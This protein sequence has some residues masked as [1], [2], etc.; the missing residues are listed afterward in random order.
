MDKIFRHKTDRNSDLM[1]AIRDQFIVSVTDPDGVIIEVNDTFCSISQYSREELIGKDHRII[2]SGFHDSRFFKH[3]WRTLKSGKSWRGEVCNRAKNGSIYWVDSVIT[4]V[5]DE[6]GNIEKFVSIRS[7]ITRKKLLDAESSDLLNI[8]RQQYIVS[9]TDINGTIIEV[10]DAFCEISQFSRS[11]LIG[12]NHRIVNSLHHSNAFFKDMW[13]TIRSGKSWH[14]EICNRAKDKSIYWV[15]SVIAPLHDSNGN[16]D[17]FVSIRRDVT[18]KKQQE[19]ENQDLLNTI[20]DQYIMS[21][22]DAKGLITDVNSAFCE[23]SG[24]SEKDLI[25]KDHRIVNSCEHDND[26]FKKMWRTVKSEKS[27]HGEI[28]NKAKDGS[29]YWVDSVITPLHDAEGRVDRFVSIRR[30]V[31]KK[32]KQAQ[33]LL[34]NKEMLDRT[35]KLAKIGGWEF[36]L[37]DNTIIWSKETCFIHGVESGYQPTLD[38]AIGFYAPEVQEK[39]RHVIERSI[40]HGESWDIEVPLIRTNGE[41]IHVRVVGSVEYDDDVASKLIGAIQD[42]SEQVEHREA[43]KRANERMKLAAD[44]GKIGIFEYDIINDVLIW[45]EWMY[46]LYGL[47]PEDGTV[48]YKSWSSHLHP[49]DRQRTER[50]FKQALDGTK[51]F[52]TEFRITWKDGSVRHIRGTATVE[53]DD[54]G[55]ALRMIGVNWDVSG[56]TAITNELAEQRELLQVT[57]ESIGDAVVT[58]DA[59]GITQWLNP[60]AERLTGWSRD[61]VEGLPLTQIFKIVNEE[62]REEVENPVITC[63]TTRQ[64]VGMAQNTILISKDGKEYGIEDSA[65]P[66]KNSSGDILGAVLVFHDVTEQRRLSSE[67]SYRAKHDHLTGLVNRTEFEA[68]LGQLLGGFGRKESHALLFIDLDQFKVLNDTCGHSIGDAALIQVS[69]LLQNLVRS[70]DIVARLGGDEFGI[71]LEHCNQAQALK[72]SEKICETMEDY[73]FIHESNSFRLGTSIGL[74]SLNNKWQCSSS[75]MK[76]ADNACYAAKEAG[77][78]RVHVFCESDDSIKLMNGEVQ[79][80]TRIE[81]ALDNNRFTLYAQKLSPLQS[82]GSGV[83]AEVLLRMVEE[84]GSIVP[85]NAFFPAAE[86]FHLASRIDR[87]VIAN[88][89][90]W[91]STL[92]A[93]AFASLDRLCVNLSGQSVGDRAFHDYICEVL[94][95]LAVN[96]RK[97]LCIEITET[98]AITNLADASQFIERVKQLGLTIALDD[99]G[100]GAS[101][102]GYLKNLDIDVLKI[103]GQFIKNLVTDTLD[104]V[105]VQCFVNVARAIG[106]KTVAEFV[107]K[108]E[109]LDKVRE[110]GV[111][112]AQGYL[113]HRPE[114]LSSIVSIEDANVEV[115]VN[116]S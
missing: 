23:I 2:N 105:T 59:N 20:R 114:Q 31:T 38:D 91:L 98:S 111:D 77:K 82:S 88:T 10:N 110:L 92:D 16:V 56:I 44:S 101:S 113:L 15:D 63:L 86:R 39:V 18:R 34:N 41:R 79:W 52:D 33:E 62:T 3:L 27:W 32:K 89:V 95:K 5:T 19:S 49:N 64:T 45:D 94:G 1:T 48:V 109:V 100:A 24:Y 69:K 57:L 21:V 75:I 112:F 7:D 55:N 67:V 8:I 66:I 76:A 81:R 74:V 78:N 71:I 17:R 42:V 103:D 61:Q 108:P 73:R 65:A 37:L 46:K 50:E 43:V 6:Q 106:L 80:S 36:D 9:I 28:C 93:K 87:W 70:S 104:E 26:F 116:A 68:R 99:F 11:E 84:D 53:R 40:N 4:P 12:Q 102:F 107:D 47:S 115:L 60:T 14:G 25:G 72:I 85:P 96:A 58:T 51:A 83:H 35:G 29:I 54:M 30:D 22:T 90:E 13:Q 97:K